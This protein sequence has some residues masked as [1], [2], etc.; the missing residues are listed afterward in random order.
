METGGNTRGARRV[1]AIRTSA[2]G[3]LAVV[4]WPVT[5]APPE[6]RLKAVSKSQA[7]HRFFN[8]Q[9]RDVGVG[10]RVADW[11]VVPDRCPR[12]FSSRVPGARAITSRSPVRFDERSP[13]VRRSLASGCLQRRIVQP[14]LASTRTPCSARCTC[15]ATKGSSSSD[16]AVAS[17]LLARPSEAQSSHARRSLSSSAAATATGRKSSRE[18]SKTWPDAPGHEPGDSPLLCPSVREC[19]L[20]RRVPMCRLVT[21]VA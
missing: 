13:T 8:L 6:S 10:E 4:V 9:L 1:L 3:E 11:N 14:S 2:Q 19:P 20:A 18:S 12:I 21:I 7:R 15:S 5:E 16:G 17:R